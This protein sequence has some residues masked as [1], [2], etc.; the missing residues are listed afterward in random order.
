MKR[1]SY[2]GTDGYMSPEILMGLEFGLETDVFSLG[3]K[4]SHLFRQT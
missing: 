4:Q 1:M 3:A 2:C